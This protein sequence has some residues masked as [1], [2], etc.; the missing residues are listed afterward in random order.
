[1]ADSKSTTI[2]TIYTTLRDSTRDH[3]TSA[4]A[5]PR[6][7][8]SYAAHCICRREWRAVATCCGRTRSHAARAVICGKSAE[9]IA[10]TPMRGVALHGR[11]AGARLP[12]V[13][14]MG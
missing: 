14:L 12:W 2:R 1:M 10:F 3:R 5:R 8:Q 4:P 13:G 11:R 9:K 6:E 7:P